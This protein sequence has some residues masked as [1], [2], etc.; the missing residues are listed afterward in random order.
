MAVEFTYY[1]RA[2]IAA[3]G[4]QP[5]WYGVFVTRERDAALAYEHGTDVPPW[6]VVH[7]LLHEV[8]ANS[9]QPR[10]DSAEVARAYTLHHAAVTAQDA[11][12][13]AGAALRTR[14]DA[15]SRAREAAAVRAR[16]AARA[17]DRAAT[18]ANPSV[19]ARLA[20]ILAWS[21]D[22][23]TRATARYEELAA[24]MRAVGGTVDAA[25]QDPRHGRP[26]GGAT[27]PEWA[28]R[29][30]GPGG[31]RGSGGRPRGARFAGAYDPAADG[32][33][34]RVP[35]SPPPA[36]TPRG[37]RFAGA[38]EAKGEPTPA[39]A[40]SG[41]GSSAAGA[42]SAPRGARF[43]GAPDAAVRPEPR[44]VD[45][46]WAAEARA[47]AL[48]LGELRR[49]GQSGAA[50]LVLCEAADGPAER[51]PYLVRELE[52]TGLGAD[53]ATLLWE[54]AALPP[55]ALAAAASALTVEGRPDD[56]RTLLR[57]AAARPPADVAVVADL[58]LHGAGLAAE[59]GELLETVARARPATDA[60]A[61]VRARPSLAQPLLSAAARVSS[62]RWRD[63]SAALR[64]L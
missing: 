10:A 12:P 26:S 13:G 51:I 48:R 19:A 16:E 4:E 24:R 56:C 34:A 14:L 25:D 60:A 29:A 1:Y 15:A 58:L 45:P 3:L 17:H 41:P 23:L 7:T 22:D 57:Q 52:R 43:A 63:I 27:R 38:P 5:G 59:A 40:E 44:P 35:E 21:R 49:T 32:A 31:K 53:V 33:S 2:L 30:D 55:Q 20:S 50:Y 42:G 46:R 39:V 8:A 54:V 11:A 37:A 28:A 61:L 62:P 64:T 36:A 6:D 9:G 47:G 18:G